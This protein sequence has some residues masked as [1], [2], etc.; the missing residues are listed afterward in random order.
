[1]T[2]N[3]DARTALTAYELEQLRRRLAVD[4][5]DTFAQRAGSSRAAVTQAAAGLPIR[6]GTAALIRAALRDAALPTGSAA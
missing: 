6:R 5:A 2:Q 4:G 1:M 3:A